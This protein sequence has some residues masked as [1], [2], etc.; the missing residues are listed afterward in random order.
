M[1]YY[2]ILYYS[3]LYIMYTSAWPPAEC[4]QKHTG[5]ILGAAPS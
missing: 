2:V 5:N 4:Q 1:L 3:T